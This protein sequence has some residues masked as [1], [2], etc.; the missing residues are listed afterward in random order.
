MTVNGYP[1]SQTNDGSSGIQV[2]TSLTIESGIINATLSKKDRH[3]D[4]S[5]AIYVTRDGT[6]NIKGGSITATGHSRWALAAL[7]TIN[8]SNGVFNIVG[9]GKIAVDHEPSS[10][11]TLSGGT[12]NITS[13]TGHT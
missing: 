7:G 10:N 5:G 13:L 9:D 8:M 11:F 6:L 4:A 1:K 12:I 2:K 3:N